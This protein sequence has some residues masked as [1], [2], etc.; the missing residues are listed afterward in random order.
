MII[1]L[2]MGGN[3]EG[4]LE[5]HFVQVSNALGEHH[6]VHVI[7][8]EKYTKRFNNVVVHPVLFT[9]SRRNLVLLYSVLRLLREISPDIVHAQ[10][11]K[12]VSVIATLK[13]FLP[14]RMKLV[15]TLHSLKR[16]LVAYEKYDWVIGVSNSVLKNLKN[17]NKS[18]IYNGVSLAES[19][20][21]QRRYL[22]DEFGLSENTKLV[23]SIGRLVEV[24]RFDILIDAFQG[25]NNACLLIV[26]DGQE[27]HKLELQI[28][29]LGQDNIKLLGH[30]QDN[31]EILSAADL[32]VISSEREG[33][34]YV[35]AES[36]LSGTPV[37]STDV[38][39]MKSIL[40][41][42]AVVKVN[43][44][45]GL[46]QQLVYIVDNYEVFHDSFQSTFHWAQDNFSFK[47]MRD[48]IEQ[49]YMGILR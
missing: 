4:G 29:E 5:S 41:Q 7:V 15:A 14:K 20:L 32:C 44:I 28:K 31:I 12:A 33:F 19:R 30:R 17:P 39:D 1:C 11:N 36:L 3:E 43:D 34:S 38:A 25:I 10:A 9:R 16:N 27:R 46:N 26:G 21:Q 49:V 18:F 13:P 35:M 40:P 2:I 42:G 22:L 23:V 47:K 6:E 8:H 45:E 24:K 37:I 48:S